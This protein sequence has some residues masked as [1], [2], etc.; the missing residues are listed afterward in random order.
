MAR[1]TI[2]S[3]WNVD[4]GR[5]CTIQRSVLYLHQVLSGLLHYDRPYDE[6]VSDR[7]QEYR[8]KMEKTK[9][10]QVK[11]EVAEPCVVEEKVEEPATVVA[12]AEGEEEA[13]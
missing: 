2:C 1:F 10:T 5:T 6:K 11:E 8:A 7:I 12:A 3:T 13:K 9:E 4:L